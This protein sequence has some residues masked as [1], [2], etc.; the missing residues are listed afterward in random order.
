[1]KGIFKINIRIAKAS[2]KLENSN[3]CFV[4]FVRSFANFLSFSA[5]IMNKVKYVETFSR[6]VF[7]LRNIF[8]VIFQNIVKFALASGFPGLDCQQIILV[9]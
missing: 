9:T 7:P 1:M 4:L 6:Q 8:P 2:K 3:R 5:Y